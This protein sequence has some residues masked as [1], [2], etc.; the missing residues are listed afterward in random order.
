GR[1]AKKG[2]SVAGFRRPTQGA[3]ASLTRNPGT[4]TAA[5]SVRLAPQRKSPHADQTGTNQRGERGRSKRSGRARPAAEEASSRIV[6]AAEGPKASRL[7]AVRWGASALYAGTRGV[8]RPRQFIFRIA[9]HLSRRARPF[10]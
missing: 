7:S 3:E 9:R 10:G 2:G 1:D 8:R 6:G 5:R 4:D